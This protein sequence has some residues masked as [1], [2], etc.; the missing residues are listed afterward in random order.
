MSVETSY[1]LAVNSIES[2]QADR[3]E[4]SLALFKEFKEKYPSSGYMAKAEE[5]SVEAKE[6]LEQLKTEE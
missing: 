6:T 5:L 4:Q 2:K 3:F 1:N